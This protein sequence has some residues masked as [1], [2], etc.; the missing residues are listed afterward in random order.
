MKAL[1]LLLMMFLLAGIAAAQTPSSLMDAPGVVVTKNSWRKEV[2]NPALDEDPLDVSQDQAD[3]ERAR[4]ETIIENAER[5]KANQPPLRIPTSTTSKDTPG[6]ISTEYIY[7]A[8]VNNTGQKTIRKLTWE[9]VLFDP[10]TQHQVGHHR[11][12]NEVN[13]RPGKTASLVG[14]TKFPPA[15]IVDA[16]KAGEE[17]P[18]QYSE[19]VVIYRIE[20]KDGPAWERPSN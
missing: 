15:S 10:K 19:Q 5:A 3:L 4:K 6:R 12:E 8:T 13:I 9:Y 1:N 17:A 11:F 2:R 16:K 14:R 7:N 20:F 18:G